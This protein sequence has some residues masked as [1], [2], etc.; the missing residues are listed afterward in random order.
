ML[1]RSVNA[2]GTASK[3]VMY[4]AK[5]TK[6]PEVFVSKQDITTKEELPGATLVIRDKDGKELVKWVSSTTPKKIT[7][8]KPGKYT[9]EETIA[10]NGYILSNE[11]KEFTVKE[12][13]SVTTVVFY[14]KAEEKVEEP[15]EPN[16]VKISKQ[17]IATKQELPGA[18]LVIKDENGKELYRWVST[19]EARY[20]ELEK[21]TYTL[22]EIQ[23]PDGY[24]LSTEKITFTVNEDGTVDKE[25]IMYNTKAVEVPITS[26]SVSFL[27]YLVGLLGT[28][29]GF[30]KV[31]KNAKQ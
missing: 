13:G 1:F 30:T 17:D 10:P 23:A 19:N 9:L 6:E 2:D 22:E 5:E 15:K 31:Y 26:S 28:V 21:G 16:K 24:I 14:N 4:N 18:T 29:F 7:G 3:V 12:D 11:K 27:V 8:L 25:V 20:V